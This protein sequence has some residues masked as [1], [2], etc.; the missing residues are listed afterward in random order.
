[1][2]KGQEGK[3]IEER[4][5]Q[6]TGFPK[7][8]FSDFQV[9]KYSEGGHH[10]PHIDQIPM[11]YGNQMVSMLV[12]LNDDYEGGEIVYHTAQPP[13]K[14]KPRKGMALVHHNTDQY[15]EFD[16]STMYAEL[17]VT[18]GE[19][20]T[21]KAW[22]YTDPLDPERRTVLPA[23]A[24]PFGGKL[25]SAVR[26]LHNTMIAKFGISNGSRYF[27]KIIMLFPSIII[28]GIAMAII[29]NN[30][31]ESK[32]EKVKEDEKKRRKKKN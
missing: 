13:V 18:K 3:Q 23:I 11:E 16:I 29:Q 6:V 15:G 2:F 7:E 21:S 24:A 12:F 28:I 10:K 4:M 31:N 32:I 5:E 26:S 14:I 25:P 9:N 17:T 8:H 27:S 1:M 19:K 30:S 22:V 20:W